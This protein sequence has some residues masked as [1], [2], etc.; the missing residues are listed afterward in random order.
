MAATA[1]W[2]DTIVEAA[3]TTAVMNAIEAATP[4]VAMTSVSNPAGPYRPATRPKVATSGIR[5]PTIAMI[6]TAD[7]HFDSQIA[8]RETG[9]DATHDRVPRSRSAMSRLIEAKIATMTTN[10]VATAVRKLVAGSIEMGPGFV[11]A[12]G[13]LATTHDVIAPLAAV[14]PRKTVVTVR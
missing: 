6:S 12:S 9:L 2:L 11:V 14:S 4:I 8:P 1:A 3:S 7:A 10:W 13:T 5:P